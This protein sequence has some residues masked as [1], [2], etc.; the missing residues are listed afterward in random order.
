MRAY[1]GYGED[2]AEQLDYIMSEEGRRRDEKKDFWVYLFLIG[3]RKRKMKNQEETRAYSRGE[4]RIARRDSLFSFP[5]RI[6][7]RFNCKQDIAGRTVTFF[8]KS[9]FI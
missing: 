4:E 1:A 7:T 3:K 5:F 2:G 8:L 6:C 9:Y